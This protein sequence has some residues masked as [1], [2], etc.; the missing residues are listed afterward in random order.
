MTNIKLVDNYWETSGIYDKV[1]GKTQREV[2]SDL[3]NTLSPLVTQKIQIN[4]G[5]PTAN[6]YYEGSTGNEIQTK[7]N[8]GSSAYQVDLS[9][10]VGKT[11][12][13]FFTT[14]NALSTRKTALCDAE[15][16][17]K[18]CYEEGS[19]S[20][21]GWN[22]DVTAENY[23]LYI[24][25][26]SYASNLAITYQEKG[27][28]DDLEERVS[29]LESSTSYKVIQP[30]NFPTL[31]YPIINVGNDYKLQT[32]IYD[33]KE[34][35]SYKQIYVDSANGSDNNDGASALT[36][37]KTLTKALTGNNQTNCFIHIANSSV[38]YADDLYGEYLVKA[39]IAIASDGEAI[40]V[41][42]VK[43]TWSLSD[44]IYT[45]TIS[46][47][48]PDI[49]VNMSASNID[50]Y[51]LY[52]PLII[53]ASLADCKT[54]SGSFFVDDTTV[55]VNPTD[56]AEIANYIVTVTQLK[57]RWNQ[58]F[59]FN[60]LLY[61]E[62][63]NFVGPSYI[64]SRTSTYVL[65]S[66]VKEVF[67]INCKCQHSSSNGIADTGADTQ[68]FINSTS[69]YNRRDNFNTHHEGL[70]GTAYD[71]SH[72]VSLTMNCNS[73]DAGYYANSNQH[74]NNNL[75][76]SHDGENVLRIN[77]H[78]KDSD[79]PCFAD[80][81]GCRSVYVECSSINTKYL[82]VAASGSW[83]FNN[84]QAANDGGFVSLQNCMIQDNR[85]NPPIHCDCDIEVCMV[86]IAGSNITGELS[87][88]V[89]V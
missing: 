43:P 61:F 26:S 25:F 63:I 66:N 41:N 71:F 14:T 3:K 19:I 87:T 81:N 65:S 53:A 15:D 20:T 35:A 13:V 5:T 12:N 79:G 44:G 2:N 82:E 74:G 8:N 49:V 62:N 69:G 47:Y 28:V 85:N 52:A 84:E 32:S 38:L 75:F 89:G 50:H 88:F 36:P 64:V 27:E 6:T 33:S 45:A 39:N 4:A 34:M 51:G 77:C 80:V 59:A 76:T 58:Q 37:F 86:N 30:Q 17:I 48:T 68:Y 54:T 23:K 24:S 78:G 7:S 73:V 1:E 16:V 83:R 40:I 57:N 9:E 42:G 10:Y 56:S 67:F 21:V 46:N 22:F 70:P 29:A 55:Y 72:Q 31:P 18:V 11:I 60:S